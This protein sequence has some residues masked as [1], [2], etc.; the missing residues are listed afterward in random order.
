MKTKKLL[1]QEFGFN[2]DAF[3]GKG[4]WYVIGKN[5]GM[6]RAASRKEAQ[7]LGTVLKSEVEPKSAQVYDEDERKAKV[8][9]NYAPGREGVSRYETANKVG[10]TKLGDL[11]ADRVLKGQGGFKALGGA[12]SDKFKARATRFKEKF[13]P[14]NIARMLTGS[15]GAAMLGSAL[16]RKKEDIEYFTGRKAQRGERGKGK[17][18]ETAD[19]MVTTISG[20]K[21]KPV[22]KEDSVADVASKL[23]GLFKNYFEKQQTQKELENNKL[24][25]YERQ[26]VRRHL[27]LL[28]AI[29][30]KGDKRGKNTAG[31]QDGESPWESLKRL[32]FKVLSKSWEVLQKFVSRVAS[33]FG[34]VIAKAKEWFQKAVAFVKKVATAIWETVKGWVTKIIERVGEIITKMTEWIMSAINKIPYV[35]EKIVELMKSGADKLS[36]GVSSMG[37]KISSMSLFK[38][39]GL[40]AEKGAEKVAAKAAGKTA[41]KAIPILGIGAGIWFAVEEAMRGNWLGAGLELSSGAAG[42]LGITPLEL[43]LSAAAVAQETMYEEDDE[44]TAVPVKTA[45]AAPTPTPSSSPAPSPSPAP[46]SAVEQPTAT[47]SASQVTPPPMTGVKLDNASKEVMLAQADTSGGSVPVVI[48]NTNN[49]ALPGSSTTGMVGLSTVRDDD[50]SIGRTIKSTLRM[51]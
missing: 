36:K 1:N 39:E 7:Q 48:N 41:L 50:S 27:E 46:A 25:G 22:Q 13:D 17:K 44:P 29:K 3:N 11:I 40:A 31:K 6:G 21:I 10:K 32:I 42:A 14:L 35:G 18:K 30:G 33:F 15:G 24:E 26:R 37:E 51:V 16:G 5:G 28:A 9:K 12:V 2:P 38:A 20:A 34:K 8:K 49:A 43:G 23:Y 45:S 19:P 47:A 4:Y